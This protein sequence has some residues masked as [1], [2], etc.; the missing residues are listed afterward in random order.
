MK[1]LFMFIVCISISIILL[2]SLMK[3]FVVQD[4][5]LNRA[6]ESYEACVEKEYGMTPAYYY[7]EQ[8]EYPEVYNCG[9]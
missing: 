2:I 4:Q 6:V 9:K 7:N 1:K 5:K 3:W 8:G